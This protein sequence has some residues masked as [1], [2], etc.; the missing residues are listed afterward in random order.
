MRTAAQCAKLPKTEPINCLHVQLKDY[1]VPLLF[2][3]WPRIPTYF[4]KNLIDL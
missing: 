4:V 3:L 1:Y 2:W